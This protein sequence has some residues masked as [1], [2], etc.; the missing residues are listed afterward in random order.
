MPAVSV[1]ILTTLGIAFGTILL[2][3]VGMWLASLGTRDAG[4]VDIVWGPGFALV[5]WIESLRHPPESFAAQALLASV[6]IWAARLGLHLFARHRLSESEDARYAAMRAADPEGFPMA[7]LGKVFA[8][9]AVILFG[10]ALPIHL[11]LLGGGAS[12]AGWLTGIGIAL[13]LVGFGLETWADLRLLRFRA[14]R[15]NKGKLLTDP[16]FSWCR[17]PNYFGES[18]LWFG[19]GLMAW[20]ASGRWWALLA[21]AALTFLLLRVSGVPLLDD[22]LARTRPGYADYA[23]RTPAFIPWPRRG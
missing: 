15:G 18:V 13:F 10:L 4:I 16:P 22:H 12:P 6:T 23:A 17:H 3:F 1:D 20:D 19:I 5:A 9:Q 11:A 7:S 2:L 21:P 14:E 8:L